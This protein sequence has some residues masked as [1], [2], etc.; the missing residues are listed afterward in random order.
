MLI[1]PDVDRLA[2]HLVGDAPELAVGPGRAAHGT[3]IPD[4]GD[5]KAGVLTL[6]RRA[7]LASEAGGDGGDDLAGA[8]TLMRREIEETE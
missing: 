3:A 6:V 2:G 4:L 1:E 5:R 8:I 7:V